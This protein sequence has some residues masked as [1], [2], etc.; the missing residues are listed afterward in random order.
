VTYVPRS[1]VPGE[2]YIKGW[3]LLPG[4][5]VFS[6]T[7]SH[8]HSPTH[9]GSLLLSRSAQTLLRSLRSLIHPFIHCVHSFLCVHSFHSIHSYMF[10]SLTLVVSI[11]SVHSCLFCSFHELLFFPFT[12]LRSFILVRSTAFHSF[13]TRTLRALRQSLVF[14]SLFRSAHPRGAQLLTPP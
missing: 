6:L 13:N 7:T 1:S 3:H 4:T 12:T 5:L 2:S 9:V 8:P 10:V 11:H 14:D